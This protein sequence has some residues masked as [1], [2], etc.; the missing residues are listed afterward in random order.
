MPSAALQFPDTGTFCDY[1]RLPDK[2]QHD[3][4]KLLKL[5]SIDNFYSLT[6]HIHLSMANRTGKVLFPQSQ[7]LLESDITRITVINMLISG[8][9]IATCQRRV[10]DFTTI[11]NFFNSES[12]DLH[13]ITQN[14]IDNFIT[15]LDSS[16]YDAW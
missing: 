2:V 11:F 7:T 13:Y 16:S 10:H 8:T 1:V 3:Y 14:S 5:Y 15:H 12:L 6:W 9:A 4:A